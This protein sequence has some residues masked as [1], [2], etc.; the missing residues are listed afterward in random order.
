MPGKTICPK[1]GS[2][3]VDPESGDGLCTLCRKLEEAQD[4]LREETTPLTDPPRSGRFN[5]PGTEYLGRLFPNLEILKQIGQGGMGVVYSARQK[6]LDRVVALKI[7]PPEVSSDSAFAER[8]GREARSL[9]RLN[10]PNII[11]VHDC[12]SVEGLFYILMEY[13]E[14]ATLRQMM[15][16]GRLCRSGVR[17]R[18]AS[19]PRSGFWTMFGIGMPPPPR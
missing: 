1:C 15:K 7:L 17:S 9:A 2:H 12:A 3:E 11:V 10:H 19:R 13:V 16:S 8:F 6:H 18:F 14:G 5:S 4:L